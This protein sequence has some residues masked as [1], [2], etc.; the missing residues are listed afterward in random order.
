MLDFL[1]ETSKKQNSVN[2]FCESIRQGIPSAVFGVSGAFKN[3]LVSNIDSKVVYVVKDSVVA[4]S[5]V[6]QLMEFTHKKVIYIPPRD[7]NLVVIK[8]F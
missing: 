2:E 6:K 3:Y 4:E 7:V 5:H 1:F 8:A